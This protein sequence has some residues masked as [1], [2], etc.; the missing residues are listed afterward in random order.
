MR[1]G[2]RLNKGGRS[3]FLQAARF[4]MALAAALLVFGQ[5]I[6][7]A[8]ALKD[9]W[10]IVVPGSISGVLPLSSMVSDLA[11]LKLL[12]SSLLCLVLIMVLLSVIVKPYLAWKLYVMAFVL[13]I[14]SVTLSVFVTQSYATEH[15]S[16]FLKGGG[17]VLGRGMLTLALLIAYGHLTRNLRNSGAEA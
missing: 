12:V 6:P 2:I 7:G 11:F 3:R 13:M 9:F 10:M 5:L 14:V 17:F 15:Q 4:L 8:Y 16:V 1:P